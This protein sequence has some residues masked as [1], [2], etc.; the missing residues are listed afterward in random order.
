MVSFFVVVE[1]TVSVRDVAD[2]MSRGYESRKYLKK[3]GVV[4]IPH[5]YHSSISLSTQPVYL[6]ISSPRY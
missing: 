2:E 4:D 5:R 3:R 1:Q 6:L